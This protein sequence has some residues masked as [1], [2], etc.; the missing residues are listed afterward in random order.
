MLFY[1]FYL[2]YWSGLLE[3]VSAYINAS[4]GVRASKALHHRLIA[5]C[6]KCP[7][8]IYTSTPIGRFLNRFSS[9]VATVDYVLPFTYRSLI[10]CVAGLAFTIA[11]IASS[12]P[13]FLL[14]VVILAP[15]YVA[16]QVS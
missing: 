10:N 5:S 7:L 11:V 14:V 13:W 1:W 9:D 8:H 6:L 4:A 3:M 12:L 16:V 15:V 2:F